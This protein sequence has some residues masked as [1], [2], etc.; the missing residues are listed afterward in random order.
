M[1][2]PMRP[3]RFRDRERSSGTSRPKARQPAASAHPGAVFPSARRDSQTT[4][5]SATRVAVLKNSL[6]AMTRAMGGLIR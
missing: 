5:F 6:P 4:G 3:P 1:K 2:R